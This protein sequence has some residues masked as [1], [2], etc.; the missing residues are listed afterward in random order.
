LLGEGVLLT[1]IKEIDMNATLKKYREAANV[2]FFLVCAPGVASALTRCANRTGK[3]VLDSRDISTALADRIA[4]AFEGKDMA[5][6][7]FRR[8][9]DGRWALI[10]H[11]SLGF[12]LAKANKPAKTS[13]PVAGPVTDT[14]TAVKGHCKCHRCHG[15]GRIASSRDDGL[16]YRC[17]GKGY[18]TEIDRRR[19]AGYAKFRKARIN[20]AVGGAA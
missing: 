1:T 2:A 5:S 12:I 18:T 19:N 14:N 10:V 4:D 7:E 20:R 9:G 15:T 8:R 6:F 3:T 11:R 13:A 16:C 17:K